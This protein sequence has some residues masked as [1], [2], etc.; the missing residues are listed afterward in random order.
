MSAIPL[1]DFTL[2]AKTFTIIKVINLSFRLEIFLKVYGNWDAGNLSN[3]F[4]RTNNLLVQC[5]LA[6]PTVSGAVINID[7]FI[8]FPSSTKSWLY[9]NFC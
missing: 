6:K 5:V 8:G 3:N 1:P 4:A 2:V 9:F 7:I